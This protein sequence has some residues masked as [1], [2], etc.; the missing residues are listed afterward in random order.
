MCEAN[1]HI[2]DLGEDEGEEIF[3]R[4]TSS[5]PRSGSS[6][7]DS[8]GRPLPHV[9]HGTSISSL[10][11]APERNIQ[12]VFLS[13]RNPTQ[14]P[15]M[16]EDI[17]GPQT[18]DHRHP[19]G[20]DLVTTTTS[21]GAVVDDVKADPYLLGLHSST[22][23]ASSGTTIEDTFN[24]TKKAVR[25]PTL[26]GSGAA[27]HS[28]R[29]GAQTHSIPPQ[30]PFRL[31]VPYG[32]RP[33][34]GLADHNTAGLAS[35]FG[36]QISASE[37]FDS[38]S[39]E[40]QSGAQQEASRHGSVA[41][42]ATGSGS[43]LSISGLGRP[44]VGD[45]MFTS[46]ALLESDAVSEPTICPGVG[47]PIDPIIVGTE[48]DGF[49]RPRPETPLISIDQNEQ[50]QPSTSSPS[51]L[52]STP[53]P[54]H[55]M[56]LPETSSRAMGDQPL[57]QLLLEE[58]S[59]DLRAILM[60]GSK[61]LSGVQ[62]KTRR[63]AVMQAPLCSQMDDEVGDSL[64]QSRG[65]EEPPMDMSFKHDSEQ[66]EKEATSFSTVVMDS[67][68]DK[69]MSSA[70]QSS[71]LDSYSHWYSSTQATPTEDPATTSELEQNPTET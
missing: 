44:G 51:A 60:S 66:F 3:F 64:D 26:S 12:N 33:P 31:S 57:E 52:T 20:E 41:L 50:P 22:T 4:S 9:E 29:L 55:L 17:F 67:E 36:S 5:R 19:P 56:G 13:L 71:A 39:L 40:I 53:G 25:Q 8:H 61:R 32:A 46:P 68:V 2:I 24:F 35:S 70:D 49:K 23:S 65:C 18:G 37:E 42:S 21:L 69:S 47:T 54:S 16:V 63:R 11:N 6:L 43:D 27:S 30:D 45:K 14:A 48:G 1:G 34:T 28:L 62:A 15:W 58:Q 10:E 59:M 7:S 38:S